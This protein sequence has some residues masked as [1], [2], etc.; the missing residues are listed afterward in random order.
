MS[1]QIVS[2]FNIFLD[3]DRGSPNS[4]SKGDDFELNLTGIN[5]DCEKGQLI[6]LTVNNFSMYKSFPNVNQNNSKFKLKTNKGDTIIDL[7]HQNY[8][9]IYD[10]ATNFVVILIR[11][12]GQPTRYMLSFF[13]FLYFLERFIKKRPPRPRPRPRPSP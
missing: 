11:Q 8:K 9:S 7:E 3:S 5:I 10:I 1:E 12:R 13:S 4:S 2:S 6:R